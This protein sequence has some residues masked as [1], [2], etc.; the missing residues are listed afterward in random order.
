MVG[1]WK[2]SN[3]SSIVERR[4]AEFGALERDRAEGAGF[5]IFMR[6]LSD[7]VDRETP[8]VYEVKCGDS[9]PTW[10]ILASVRNEI[11]LQELDVY[12]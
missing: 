4:F 2:V 6:L 11:G 9:H 3:E 7:P 5:S 12:F 8:T 1:S 10:Y